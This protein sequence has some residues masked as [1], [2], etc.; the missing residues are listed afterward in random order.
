MYSRLRHCVSTAAVTECYLIL[1]NLFVVLLSCRSAAVSF[2]GSRVR[3][4]FNACTFVICVFILCLCNGLCDE[5][6]TRSDESYR[7]C[8]YLCLLYVPQQ[9]VTIAFSLAAAPQKVTQN[10]LT[11]TRIFPI[12]ELM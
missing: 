4:P 6:V 11:D 8:L 7:A 9:T 5:L 1:S 12:W 10:L 3:T 2:L